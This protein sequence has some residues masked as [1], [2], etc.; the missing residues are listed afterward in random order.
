MSLKAFGVEAFREA[1]EIGIENALYT[2]GLL[3]QS[4]DWEIITPA[5]LGILTFRFVAKNLSEDQLSQL[6]SDMAS[7]MIT[8]GYAMLS[9]TVMRGKTV[10]RMCTINP[11]T[12]RGDIE[13]TIAKLHEIGVGMGLG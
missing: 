12:T 13:T 7:E 1:I 4:P 8:S 11:R 5:S 6:N 3:R 9:P 2:E 10:Q